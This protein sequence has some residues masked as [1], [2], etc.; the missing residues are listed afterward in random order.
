M[1]PERWKEVEELYHAALERPAESRADFLSAACGDD[2]DLH[3]E[4][5]S[6]LALQSKAENFIE[7]PALEV[8]AKAV[9]E[10]SDTS[11]IGKQIGNYQILSLLGQ[12]GM[13]EV[14]LA[15]DAKLGRKVALKFL[16]SYSAANRDRLRRFEQEAR[17]A[18]ALNHPNI[19]TIH[20]I[21]ET[22]GRR[23]IATEFIDG[24]TLRQRLTNGR[25]KLNE[26]L[27]IAIQTADALCAAHEAGI[28][29]RDIKP[30]NIMLRRRD[31]IV[32]VLDFGLA[33][34]SRQ[35]AAVIDIEA[36]T[37]ALLKTEP[38]VVMGTVIYMSPE[39]ARGLEVDQRTDIWS[40]GVV[41]YEMVAGCLPFEAATAGEG[42]AAILSEKEPPPLARFAREVPAELE[43]I[44]EKALRKDREERYQASKEMLLDLKSLKRRL[45]FEADLERS[46]APQ[47]DAAAVVNSG[48]QMP[49][50]AAQQSA[51]HSGDLT[52]APT[53]SSAEYLVNEIKQRKRGLAVVLG[54]FVLSFAGLTY[55]YFARGSK[56]TAI[57]SLA[58][59]PFVNVSADPNTEYLSDGITESIISNLSQLPQLKVMARSTVFR[60]K[61]KEID[62]QKIGRDLNVRAVLSGRLLQQGDSLVIRTEL[63]NVADGTQ[64]WGAEYNRK[65]SDVLEV[66][67]DI[68]RDISAKLRLRLTGEDEKR[69]TK[70][71]TENTEAYQ[72][73]LKGR[74]YWNKRTIDA[75]KKAIEF[76][77]QA[78][79]KDPNYA[80][81]YS[82]LADCYSL[83][84]YPLAPKEKYPLARQ[85][86]LKAIELDDTLAEPHTALGRVK[87]EYDWDRD[88]AERE[89]KRAIE[90]SPNSSLVH[91]RYAG[92]L[93]L[94]GKHDEA[95][96]ESK[97]AVA[98]D[99]LSPLI[100]WGLAYSYYWARRYDEA[101]E[102]DQ[103]TLEIDASFV[104]SYQQLGASYERKGIY[105]K[106]FEYYLKWAALTDHAE[107]MMA[108]KEAY[109]TTGVKGYYLKQLDQVIARTKQ[110]PQ[111][112]LEAAVLS[113]QL[114]QKEQAFEWLQKAMEERPFGLMFLKVEPAFDNM[115]SDPRFQ[116]L[117]R[118]LDL[119]A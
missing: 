107:E 58:V 4:V 112:I 6:L 76:F 114:G 51:T 35:P 68:S 62:P 54:V 12:G 88:G 52:R 79:E 53:T 97:E 78:L 65:L 104:R 29:H 86:A 72:L 38:G 40:F 71:Y 3:R 17:S 116:D 111:S 28:V 80:L 27:N 19:L 32:K 105:D 96:A 15:E 57:D 34:L 56:T 22:D 63:V 98:L 44:V 95:I 25:L 87:Q 48:G 43:R 102:Q 89:F 26:A 110:D 55:F 92:F 46:A 24:E 106:A 93:T 118:R 14:Y 11:V 31:G 18:S 84:D 75:Y 49:M 42:L 117:L 39:Q 99:P 45:E 103:K 59:L 85:S 108:Q 64:L 113:A 20:E 77:N 41:L 83:G 1:K 101:I 73:Y 66:Q 10:D 33:K 5:E 16:P 21:G 47:T 23:F 69:L 37:K 90:L 81:A 36:P 8:A 9:A 30:E 67:R 115:R 94:L 74:F 50:A 2:E 100:N 91:F 119:P 109:A 61:G 82:G 7:K 13:G 70:H 60:F